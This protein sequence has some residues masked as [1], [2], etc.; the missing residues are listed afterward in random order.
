MAAEGR[1]GGQRATLAQQVACGPGQSDQVRRHGRPGT[2]GHAH[3]RQ[4]EPAADQRRCEQEADGGGDQ[5][6]QQ[7]GAGVA[8]A[9]QHG[10]HEQKG[11]HAWCCDQHDAGIGGGAGQDVGRRAQCHQHHVGKAAAENGHDQT[12]DQ[13]GHERRAGNGL[14]PIQLSRSPSL[15]DQDRRPG[16]E[17]D[18]EGDQEKQHREEGRHRC[19]GL[20]TEHL[21]QIDVVDGAGDGL[22]EVAENHRPEE[23]QVAPPQGFGRCGRVGAGRGGGGHTVSFMPRRRRWRAPSG[24]SAHPRARR[25]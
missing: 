13:A 12:G 20:H 7:G 24:G 11:E 21:P 14:D 17:T 1:V 18:H 6:G 2:A 16:T 25:Q 15:P 4:T 10:G 9:A 3:H 22:Q 19:H 23:G 5:Q 8:H